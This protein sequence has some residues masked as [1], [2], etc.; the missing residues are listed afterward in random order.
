MIFFTN[1]QVLVDLN[2]PNLVN[3]LDVYFV[4]EKSK[5]FGAGVGNQRK[6]GPELWIVMEFLSGGAL[7]DLVEN[8][9]SLCE[10][11]IAA[12]SKEVRNFEQGKCLTALKGNQIKCKSTFSRH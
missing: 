4:E 12:I 6:E 7:T 1:S 10:K 8:C 5:R 2:H 9:F 11:H 3:C